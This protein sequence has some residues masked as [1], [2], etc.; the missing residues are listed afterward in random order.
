MTANVYSLKYLDISYCKHLV[1]GTL[2]YIG[3]GLVE[4]ETLVMS[5]YTALVPNEVES[6]AASAAA[7][8]KHFDI[9]AWD[10]SEKVSVRSELVK[11]DS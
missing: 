2:Y 11:C 7:H 8:L 5:H 1:E 9:S 6:L 4:L 3:A 10:I